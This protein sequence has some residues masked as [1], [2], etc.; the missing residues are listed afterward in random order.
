MWRRRVVVSSSFRLV[1][2]MCIEKP[3]L[4]ICLRGGERQEIFS[5]D[6]NKKWKSSI[7]SEV[8]LL[9]TLLRLHLPLALFSSM[10][11]R[12]RRLP[13]ASCAASL[14]HD[15]L[16]VPSLRVKL[17]LHRHN[18]AQHNPP[19]I[20]TADPTSPLSDSHKCRCRPSTMGAM[21]IILKCTYGCAGM[22]S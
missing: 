19:R 18:T 5:F 6:G 11:S 10:M 2:G 21:M 1:S 4:R 22:A 17:Q 15:R 7:A 8:L 20:R 13:P 16:P 12:R 3:N 14:L 9:H